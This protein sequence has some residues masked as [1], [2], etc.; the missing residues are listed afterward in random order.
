MQLPKNPFVAAEQYIQ[1]QTFFY[2]PTW[3]EDIKR[4]SDMVIMPVILLCMYLCGDGDLFLAVSTVSTAI[5]VWKQW[6][7]Y[8]DLHF[9]MQTMR[10]QMALRG[11]PKIVTNNPRYMPYVWAHSIS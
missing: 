6:F 3:S 11:G 7:T 5:T 9:T 8:L 2:P 4:I 10:I 1:L